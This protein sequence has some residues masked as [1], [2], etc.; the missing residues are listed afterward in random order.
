[1]SQIVNAYVGIDPGLKGGIAFG[2]PEKNLYA[3]RVT[4]LRIAGSSKSGGDKNE[5]DVVELSKW[6]RSQYQPN[7]IETVVIKAAVEKVGAMPKQGVC[8]MFNFGVSYGKLLAMLEMLSASSPPGTFGYV[9]VTPQAWKKIIL[10]GTGHEKSD[11]IAYVQNK[12]PQINL[13]PTARCTSPHD[14]M[15]DAVCLME[16][17]RVGAAVL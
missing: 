16:Y 17:A 6:M 15:A 8:S 13:L 4:P 11:A 14:G 10:S 7:P 5:I 9:R 2:I 12:Y 3:V 1:M